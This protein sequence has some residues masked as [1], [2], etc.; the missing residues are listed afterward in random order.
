MAQ[1]TLSKFTALPTTMIRESEITISRAHSGAH[2]LYHKVAKLTAVSTRLEV[3]RLCEQGQSRFWSISKADTFHHELA[4]LLA[5]QTFGSGA[6][7]L[8]RMIL[9]QQA[10]YPG[11][12]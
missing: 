3:N 1:T 8:T 10:A 2:V 7:R 5:L 12:K 11:E 9:H 6:G 4:L